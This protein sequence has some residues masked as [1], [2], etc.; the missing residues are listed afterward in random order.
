MAQ[1]VTGKVRFSYL[2]AFEP[3]SN[4]GGEPKY[5]VTLLIPK[6]DVAT[7]QAIDA[8][9][10]QTLQDGMISV[11]AGQMP[12]RPAIPLYDGDG[13]RPSGEE[14]GEEAKGHWV[15]TASSKQQPGMVDASLQPIINPNALYSGCYGRADINFFAYNAAGKKGVGCGLNNLQKLEDGEPLS[16]RK[17][18]QEVF[19]SAPVAQQPTQAPQ[20]TQPN[21]ATQQPTQ[22]GY[23]DIDPLTGQPIVIDPVTGQRV[24]QYELFIYRY[25]DVLIGGYQQSRTVQVRAVL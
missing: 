15:I 24:M 5:S 18:A 23:S 19:G 13:V 17:S 14:F 21:P 8:A 6:T 12:A 16:G 20:Y 2:N 25:R 3:R 9:I 22:Y 11:F 1:V 10:Q 4:N 7:K